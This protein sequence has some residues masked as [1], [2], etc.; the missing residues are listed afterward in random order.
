MVLSRPVNSLMVKHD[1]ILQKK[2]DIVK[3]KI[4]LP[5]IER[6]INHQQ[7]GRIA[8]MVIKSKYSTI[9]D[10]SLLLSSDFLWQ[11]KETLLLKA[12]KLYNTD[13]AE[14]LVLKEPIP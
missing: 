4:S 6:I 2:W 3:F 7:M 14:F 11:Q 1:V 5:S 9:E 12:I 10:F 8:F 13:I